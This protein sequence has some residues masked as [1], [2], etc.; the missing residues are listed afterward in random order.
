MRAY[1]SSPLLESVPLV[2]WN[3]N[4]YSPSFH[5][6][7]VFPPFK[8][9]GAGADSDKSDKL[10]GQRTRFFLRKS[11]FFCIFFFRSFIF[12]QISFGALGP[13]SKHFFTTF[14]CTC[15][16]IFLSSLQQQY[17]SVI[18]QL[19]NYFPVRTWYTYIR[20]I[21]E[22]LARVESKYGKTSTK[23][24]EREIDVCWIF[25]ISFSCP[26]YCRCNLLS[27]FPHSSGIQMLLATKIS[28]AEDAAASPVT[29]LHTWAGIAFIF[30]FSFSGRRNVGIL[31]H[32]RRHSSR[33]FDFWRTTTTTS[34]LLPRIF[35]SLLLFITHTLAENSNFGE[36]VLSDPETLF[37]NSDRS[38]FT[39]T[40]SMLHSGDVSDRL[41]W[42][43]ER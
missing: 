12:C 25:H 18:G 5:F 43:L 24:K 23:Q 10:P 38:S 35:P 29:L 27:V 8:C 42:L 13:S 4:L 16:S 3:K 26:R 41:L 31:S 20:H 37:S 32:A 9:T 2:P 1:I 36:F 17:C 7:R 15:T 39:T 30:F 19:F 14:L 21:C 33:Y 28:L 22:P 40:V 34:M 11:A 6:P